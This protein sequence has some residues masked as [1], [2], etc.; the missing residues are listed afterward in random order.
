M[1]ANNPFGAAAKLVTNGGRFEMFRLH[2][3]ADDGLGEIDTLPYSIRVLL[4]ACQ[5]GRAS[6]RERV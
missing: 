1:P 3:L 5:I 6:C 4:E 2:K